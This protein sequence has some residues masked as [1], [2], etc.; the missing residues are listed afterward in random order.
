MAL[1]DHKWLT[2]GQSQHLE[3]T[4]GADALGALAA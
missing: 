3:V 2:G 1:Q 4:P